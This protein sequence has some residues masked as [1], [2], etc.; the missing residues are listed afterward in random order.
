MPR[1][2]VVWDSDA[3]DELALA[4]MA[5]ANQE[6]V[7]AAADRIDSQLSSDPGNKGRAH[8]ESLRTLTAEPLEILFTIRDL[9]RLVRVLA[10]RR[11][12]QAG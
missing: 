9:D 1:Y 7:K 3:I 5:S 6:S 4:W 12:S 10:V 2:T 8:T 11:I